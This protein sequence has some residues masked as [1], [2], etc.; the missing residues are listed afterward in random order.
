MRHAEDSAKCLSLNA[1]SR[2][3]QSQDHVAVC[4]SEVV[5]DETIVSFELSE[6]RCRIE[7]GHSRSLP[8]RLEQ[9]DD[10]PSKG[11]M[12]ATVQRTVRSDQAQLF[13]GFG[14][15]HRSNSQRDRRHSSAREYFHWSW[16]AAEHRS[17]S[18]E[19]SSREDRSACAIRKCCRRPCQIHPNASLTISMTTETMTTSIAMRRT[20]WPLGA[21]TGRHGLHSLHCPSL[22]RS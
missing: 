21:A 22:L 13:S 7:V 5:L 20:T 14:V 19:A 9:A 11:G 3:N 15:L 16:P 17:T 12:V 1:Q 2:L 8:L 10:S 18:G 6:A 4:V